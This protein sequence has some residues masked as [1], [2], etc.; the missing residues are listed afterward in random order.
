MIKKILKILAGLFA[1]LV[2]GVGTLLA[3]NWTLVTRGLSYPTDLEITSADWYTPKALVE[4]NPT[5]PLP[6]ADSL[7]IPEEALQEIAKYA[8]E[9]NSSSLLIMHRDQIILEKY[10][11]G[12]DANSTSNSMS[13]AK[14]IIGLLIGIAIEEGHLQSEEE[15]AHTYL[16]E[17]KDDERS[18]ITIKD[19]LLMQSGLVNE[20]NTGDY[21][22]DLVQMYA[23]ADAAEVALSVPA[24]IPPATQ[25]E[26][27]NA[28]TQLMAIILERATGKSIEAYASEK[29]WQ[30]IGAKDAGWWMDNAVGM[31]KAFCCFF[32]SARDWARVGRVIY[33]KGTVDGKQI[34]SAEWIEKMIQQSTLERDYGYHLWVGYEDGGR[35]DKNRTESFLAPLIGI[36]GASKQH[37]FVV[38]SRELIIVRIGEKP[39]DWDEAFIPNTLIRA[40]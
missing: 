31:P 16:S 34:V 12:F 3:L 19:L 35:R 11:N 26:Y 40:I 25:F 7:T 28:N 13:M 37:V 15:P 20:D 14:T 32:A 21:T 38:P 33:H 39:Q 10:W 36:D 4:G 17:W 23:G 9:R 1:L 6:T 30:P 8:E 22:S 29:L 24:R 5:Q 2:F 18:K 27:N